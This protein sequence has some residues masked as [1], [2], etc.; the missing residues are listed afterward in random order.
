MTLD[1]S[2]PFQDFFLQTNERTIRQRVFS[3]LNAELVL[4][5]RLQ[6]EIEAQASGSALLSRPLPATWRRTL[7]GQE[8]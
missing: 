2:Q 7:Q 8:R 6:A 5:D 3:A 4:L 1:A